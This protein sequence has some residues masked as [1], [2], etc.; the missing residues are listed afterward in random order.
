MIDVPVL[1]KDA[2]R[3]GR[4]LKNYRFMVQNEVT[5]RNVTYIMTFSASNS[6]FIV[7]RSV[8]LYMHIDADQPTDSI[9]FAVYFPGG[10]A[11]TIPVSHTY[12]TEDFFSIGSYAPGTLINFIAL[13]GIEYME[14][15]LTAEDLISYTTTWVDD[16]E[17]DNNTLITE[18]VNIDEAMCSDKMLKFGL[19]EGSSLEFQYF[20]H[21]SIKDKRIRA[22]VDVQ[23][24]NSGTL[25]W[26][27]IP[28][29]YYIVDSCP[30]Q[31]STGIYKVTA[32][33]KLKSAYLDA[34]A[35]TLIESTFGFEDNVLLFDVLNILLNDYAIKKAPYDE[36][37]CEI[38]PHRNNYTRPGGSSN[39]APFSPYKYTTLYGDQGPLGIW[40]MKWAWNAST[41]SNFY[42]A[43]DVFIT[44]FDVRST[45]DPIQ[46]R[47]DLDFDAIDYAIAENIKTHLAKMPIN[48]TADELWQRILGMRGSRLDT[49]YLVTNYFFCVQIE[50]NNGQYDYY[51][52]FAENSKGS[53]ADLAKISLI[54]VKYVYF[55]QPRTLDFS[56][57]LDSDGF[58]T[59]YV[60][61][62]GRCNYIYLYGANKNY[63]YKPDSSSAEVSAT[64]QTPKKPDGSDI[65]TLVNYMHV[66][67]I[68]DI[69][70][71]ELI[72]IPV[73]SLADVTL[74]DLQSSVYELNCQFGQIDRSTDLFYGKELLT[75]ALYPAETLYPS[76]SLYP[77]GWRESGFRSQYS[78]LWAD[79]LGAQTFRN[80]IITYKTLDQDNKE[81]EAKLTVR[82]NASG[83]T[84]YVM[85]D[86]WLFKNL[87]WTEEQVE[88][89]ADAMA[90]KMQPITWF[91]FEMWAAGLPYIETGDA[92][93]IILGEDTYTSYILRRILK[94]IHNLQDTY[95]DGTLEIF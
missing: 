59:D 91:P 89:Y 41:S 25:S 12:G 14:V 29:G 92:I 23:Y 54:N 63:I 68:G 52:N 71:A 65:D 47:F 2:L 27:N 61:V 70:D 58:L 9:N 75:D 82:V 57:V 7:G 45:T 44:R 84:D 50:Y 18:S 8:M 24:E 16:F 81:I 20:D 11:K 15:G 56:H 34:K 67:E 86:N 78:Q 94:G 28:M 3:D 39:P 30:R 5:T 22:C 73:A 35:N 85:D 55:F 49:S 66:T 80:L 83:T 60:N 69:T 43:A 31:A 88:E 10:G 13:P 76:D 77:G 95:I 32:Y 17:I 36:F 46:V 6:G 74:R 19:C 79:T 87:V 4:R 1:V 38:T 53:F 90:A 40:T 33:N 26:Y 93:E 72:E 42:M 37:P 48:I 64:Y 62:D 51:G 21:P